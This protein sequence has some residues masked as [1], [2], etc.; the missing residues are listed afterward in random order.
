[1]QESDC[2]TKTGEAEANTKPQNASFA[3]NTQQKAENGR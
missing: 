3:K 2:K 1:M